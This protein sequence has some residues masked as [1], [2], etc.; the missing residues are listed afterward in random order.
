[1][2][3][4]GSCVKDGP[5]G[6]ATI[7]DMDSFFYYTVHMRMCMILVLHDCVCIHMWVYNVCV[8]TG[9]SIAVREPNS[10]L[11]CFPSSPQE[12]HY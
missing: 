11:S 8:Y 2:N 9:D 1:M 4:N 12:S 10:L 5:S 7:Y 3:R 6:E